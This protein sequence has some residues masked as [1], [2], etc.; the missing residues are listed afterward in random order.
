MNAFRAHAVVG[1]YPRYPVM[2]CG[3]DGRPFLRAEPE[4]LPLAYAL[5][6]ASGGLDRSMDRA[7]GHDH[8]FAGKSDVREAMPH[9][10]CDVV[11]DE[12]Y[13]KRHGQQRKSRQTRIIS[14]LCA[15]F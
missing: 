9:L 5:T 14:G 10:L 13:G 12:G 7:R 1:I 15:A 4:P 8:N 2:T 11:C 3:F 6:V